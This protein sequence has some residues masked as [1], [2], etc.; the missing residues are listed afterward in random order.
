MKLDYRKTVLLGFGFL[1]VSLLWAMYNA[2]VPVFLQ[3][4]NPTFSPNENSASLLGFGLSATLTGFV[5]TLDN[6]AGVLI[7][8]WIGAKSDQTRTRFGRRMPY[9]MLGA[10]LSALGFALVPAAIK[11]IPAELNGQFEQLQGPF[12]V[13]LIALS[14]T[15][16]ASAIYRTPAIALMPDLIPSRFRSQANGIINLMG[17]LGFVIGLG[18]GAWLIDIDIS[19]PFIIGAAA[20]A[21]SAAIVLF[22]IKEPPPPE[23]SAEANSSAGLIDNLRAVWQDEDKHVLNLLVAIFLWFLAFNAL[24]TF[25]TSYATFEL[26]LSLGEASRLI[27]IAGGALILFAVPAG[28]LAG[29]FGRKRTI[30]VGLGGFSLALV[31]IYFTRNTLAVSLALAVVGGCWALVNINSLP[32]VV[33]SVAQSQVGAYTGLYYFASLSSAI[34]G[35]IAIGGVIELLGYRSMFLFSMGALGLAALF[36]SRVTRGE[37][38]PETVVQ[39]QQT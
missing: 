5:M 9:I 30:I 6:I 39:P 15:L 8:P 10:P 7:Q 34:A 35:P 26:G 37:A 32:M 14:I 24:E 21:G 33:D 22:T 3:A 4:G 29:R 11:Q 1:G 27:M 25:L 36:L 19:L 28:F 16:L 31:F 18:T 38:Q 13:F 2:Y 17:G 20:V 23:N 12:I